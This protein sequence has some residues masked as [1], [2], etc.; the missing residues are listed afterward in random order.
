MLFKNNEQFDLSAE[1]RKEL[2]E[3][4]GKFPV[5]VQWMPHKIRPN[6]N[7]KLP[8]KPPAMGIRTQWTVTDKKGNKAVY[9]YAEN[10]TVD[11][12]TKV[13][14]FD[15]IMVPFPGYSQ[16]QEKDIEWV[17]FL[18][19]CFPSIKD[20][21]NSNAATKDEIMFYLPAKEK[22]KTIAYETKLTKAKMLILDPDAGLGED[23]LRKL[24]TAYFF[25]NVSELTFDQVK[26]ALMTHIQ[27]GKDEV[28]R[29]NNI[30]H[31]I[32]LHGNDEAIEMRFITQQAIEKELIKYHSGKRLYYLMVEGKIL[33][34]PLCQVPLTA[35]PKQ[36][37]YEFCTGPGKETYAI[38]KNSLSPKKVKKGN[39]EERESE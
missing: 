29:L 26:D 5:T 25:S 21:Y 14:V 39:K 7:N 6:K 23:E 9:Q 35:D 24:L 15:P 13:K 33:E 20:G 11:P 17:W 37:F 1:Q 19:H 38:L 16:Y 32:S 28:E 18:W 8:D 4:I 3:V 2:M 34:P 10:Y 12:T 31:F 22:A 30:Q 36:Y 27:R